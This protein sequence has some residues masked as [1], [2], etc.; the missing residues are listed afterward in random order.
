MLLKTNN[1]I[2]VLMS[3]LHSCLEA[4]SN[5]DKRIYAENYENGKKIIE[6]KKKGTMSEE[7]IMELED[8]IDALK[9]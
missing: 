2:N 8:K 5:K 6:A 7:Q 3:K 1:I 9:A 4:F